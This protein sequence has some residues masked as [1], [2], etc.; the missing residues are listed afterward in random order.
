MQVLYPRRTGAGREV[1]RYVRKNL[2]S[3]SVGYTNSPFLIKG[4]GLVG[5]TYSL[6]DARDHAQCERMYA[7]STYILQM[8]ER[9][10]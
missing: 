2:L 8:I 3:S 4:L 7:F 1:L 5:T 10:L 6:L 9:A